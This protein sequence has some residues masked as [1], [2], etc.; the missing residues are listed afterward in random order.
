MIRLNIT[1]PEDI[2]EKLEGIRNKSAF[3]AEALKEKFVR[4]KKEKI[5]NLL[6]DCYKNA[7]KNSLLEDKDWDNAVND[8]WE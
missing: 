5:E 7:Q 1:M 6:V 8:G 2:A 4:D 3:I